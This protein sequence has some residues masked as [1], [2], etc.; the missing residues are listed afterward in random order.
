ME[1]ATNL[2]MEATVLT[3]EG[4]LAH[5]AVDN[6]ILMARRMER[7]DMVAPGHTLRTSSLRTIHT[8]H[9]QVLLYMVHSL[10]PEHTAELP[11][12]HRQAMEDMAPRHS[13]LSRHTAHLRKMPPIMEHTLDM[14]VC[15]AINLIKQR[16]PQLSMEGMA[17]L[18]AIKLQQQPRLIKLSLE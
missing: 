14:E 13:N 4:P 6:T 1:V 9:S 15:Q 18:L 2:P 17:Q 5:T 12:E 10:R 11:G 7:Q 3:L 16:P 8:L